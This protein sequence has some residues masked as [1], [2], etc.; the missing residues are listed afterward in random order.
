MR[1][2]CRNLFAGNLSYEIDDDTVRD[3]FKE[4]GDIEAIRWLTHRDSGDFKGCGYIQFYDEQSCA[5]AAQLNGSMLMGR[6]L[7]LD[8]AT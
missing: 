4:C 6:Q 1:R 5:A 8:W 7:R 2:G 3:F